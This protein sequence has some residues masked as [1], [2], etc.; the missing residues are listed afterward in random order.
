MKK[1]KEYVEEEL[2]QKYLKTSPFNSVGGDFKFTAC[3]GE[4]GGYDQTTIYNGFVD[5][6]NTLIESIRENKNFSDP[7]V[8]PILFCLRH[9][10]ELFLKK[11]YAH[12]EYIQCLRNAPSD[13]NKLLK[14]QMIYSRLKYLQEECDS[15]IEYATFN[16][17]ETSEIQKYGSRKTILQKRL[18]KL[19]QF[20]IILNKRLF[21]K[22]GADE[23]THDLNGLI[24]KVL[25]VY[26]IDERITVLFDT[27][28]PL[29]NYYKDIDPKGDAFRYWFDK[30]GNA[31]FETKSIGSVRLDIIAI[32]FEQITSYFEKIEL[33]MWCILKEYKTGT[34][35]KELSR[36][37]IEEI[38]KLLPK[39]NE[40]SEKIKEIKEEIKQK[41]KIGS[42]K[43]NSILNLIRNHREFSANM[44]VEKPFLYLSDNAINIFAK[45]SLGLDDWESSS[46]LITSDELNLFITFSDIYGWRYSEKNYA[47]FS[48]NLD[49]LFAYNKR[50]R[51]L[52]CFDIVPKAEINYVVNGMDKCGQITYINKLKQYLEEYKL[53]SANKCSNGD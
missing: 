50:E 33:V 8:Y 39:Q 46:R 18:N 37:Q 47:Y 4:N 11:L 36:F 42:N 30:E 7:M 19:E 52:S 41:Y 28:L 27:V 29:L 49:W 23:Y 20:I 38:S 34:F 32:Q 12:L 10:I 43:F 25:G 48:E 40:F 14:A 45:C 35:T 5:T 51:N 44:G 31:H 2:L 26:Q 24:C 6:V 22:I 17:I 15:K 9:S 21:E 13:F 16:E 1:E 53:M 3:V